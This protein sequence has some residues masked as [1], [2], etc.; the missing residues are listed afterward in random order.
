MT[1]LD[2]LDL[3][4]PGSIIFGVLGP[5]GAGKTTTIQT[6]AGLIS[7]DSDTGQILNG[8]PEDRGILARLGYMPQSAALYEELTARENVSFFAA[9]YRDVSPDRVGAAIFLVGM[10]ERADSQVRTLSGG[11]RHRVSLACAIAHDPELL[12]LDEP[13]A[14]VN[15]QL[16]ANVWEHFRNMASRGTTILISSH[17]MDE[18]QR[19]SRPDPG[20]EASGRRIG[21]RDP[22]ADRR[23]QPQGSIHPSVG[24]PPMTGRSLLL[25]R[26]IAKQ[27]VRDRRTLAF[28]VVVPTTI[29]LLL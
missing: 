18:A 13:T 22:G 21:R 29:V 28:L 15:P 4:V 3:Q 25:A 2:G 20:W 8:S 5:N 7:L 11:V 10:D 14:G 27:I 6:I 26:R 19:P 23:L 9:C 24:H 1:A 17:I 12:P 16:R